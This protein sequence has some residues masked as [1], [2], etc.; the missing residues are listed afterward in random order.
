[1][2]RFVLTLALL[3][4]CLMGFSQFNDPNDVDLNPYKPILID[5]DFIG[6]DEM[7]H[8]FLS[9]KIKEGGVIKKKSNYKQPVNGG[10]A[11]ENDNFKVIIPTADGQQNTL[12]LTMLRSFTY[13]HRI[14]EG[15]MVFYRFEGDVV[16]EDSLMGG[17][18]RYDVYPL[19]FTKKKLASL[20]KAKKLSDIDYSK[21]VKLVDKDAWRYV[22]FTYSPQGVASYAAR[23]ICDGICANVSRLRSNNF[24]QR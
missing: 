8:I 3:A 11:F 23:I 24:R 13:F 19:A 10:L 5:K 18:V 15:N 14:T 2:K 12:E 20:H 9:Y 6:N 1:M 16:T 17:F 4:S 7:S 22:E 21:I